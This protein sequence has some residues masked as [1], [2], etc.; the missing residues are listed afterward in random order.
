MGKL[1]RVGVD[2]SM[3]PAVIGVALVVTGVAITAGAVEVMVGV[4]DT[5]GLAG[6]TTDESA[7]DGVAV[8]VDGAATVVAGGDVE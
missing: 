7:D 2:V 5:A 8:G 1:G 3:L 6:A 4:A